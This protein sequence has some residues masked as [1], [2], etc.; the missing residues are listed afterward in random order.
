MSDVT[1]G[2]IPFEIERK[3][4]IDTPNE[5]AISML[6]HGRV[7]EI[8]QT[9]LVR[10]V[11]GGSRRIRR[12]LCDGT[13]TYTYTEKRRVTAMT[14]YEDEHVITEAEYLSYLSREAK[15]DACTIVKTRYALPYRSHVLEVDIYPFLPRYAVLEIELPSEDT[16]LELPP[17][18]TVRRELTH[19]ARFKNAA[20]AEWLYRHPNEEFPV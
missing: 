3:F 1:P 9:Y 15:P 19:D 7:M 8:S 14:Q 12:S 16:P 4:L 18:L 5:T 2:V 11:D 20:I 13:V 6:S 17:F 10:A